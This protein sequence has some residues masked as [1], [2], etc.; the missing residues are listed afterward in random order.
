MQKTQTRSEN[1]ST[2]APPSSSQICTAVPSPPDPRLT[3]AAPPVKVALHPCTSAHQIGEEE[4][5]HLQHF[6]PTRT[7]PHQNLQQIHR[8]PPAATCAPL[9][10]TME[11]A[12]CNLHYSFCTIAQHHLLAS[13][14]QRPSP[15][16]LR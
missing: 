8:T 9:Q 14:Q 11:V 3:M 12:A 5:L 4:P 16:Q 1:V 15:P 10:A 7:A 2:F 13:T 6:P